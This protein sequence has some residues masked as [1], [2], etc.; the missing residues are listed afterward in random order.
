MTS[1]LLLT[2]G[3]TYISLLNT[4]AGLGLKGWRPQTPDYKGGGVWQDSPLADGRRLAY[5][6]LTNI[7]ETFMLNTAGAIQDDLI[8]T[9]QECRRLL[10]KAANYWGS[11]WQTQPVWLEAR[12]TCETNARYAIVMRGRMGE[13]DNPYTTPFT[14][15]AGGIGMA[16]LTLIV[17]HGLWHSVEPGI[18]IGLPIGASST[19]GGFTL[20]N[21]DGN[22]ASQ[23]TTT[24]VFI[25]NKRTTANLTHIFDTSGGGAFFSGNHLSFPKPDAMLATPP[26]LVGDAIYF[27]I[28]TSV[29][30]SGPFSSLVSNL[31]VGRAHTL[32]WEYWNGAAWFTLVP[33]LN[34]DQSNQFQLTGVKL[35]QWTP[36]ADW[37]TTAVNGVTGWWVRLVINVAVGVSGPVQATRNIYSVTWPQT[38]IASADIGGDV[39]AFINML[40][41]ET[42]VNNFDS[43]R[44]LVGARTLSRGTNFTA[45]LNAVS[46]QNPS[47]VI[48]TTS[49]AQMSSAN[50]ITAPT[51]LVSR[52]TGGASARA[53]AVRL[54][55]TL[56]D[57]LSP[58]Y[59]GAF[60]VFLRVK[61]TAGSAG[62]LGMRGL[63]QI[64]GDT[65]Y[66]GDR[67]ATLQTNIWQLV[68]LGLMR[69]PT[70]LIASRTLYSLSIQI[71]VDSTATGVTADFA[72]LILL[73]VDE[74]NADYQAVDPTDVIA[75][76]VHGRM[77]ATTFPKSGHY[78]TRY[79]D[80]SASYID[81]WQVISAAPAQIQANVDSRLWFLL[82]SR[83]SSSASGENW[84]APFLI[85]VSLRIGVSQRYLSMRG[86]R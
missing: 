43:A 24:G 47:G 2:D 74:W 27:G 17:E 57:V 81:A 5:V 85:T 41:G 64:S 4:V 82:A 70:V 77:G 80:A 39:P 34:I 83:P 14:G 8:F 51:G 58:N 65:R 66:T 53:A 38:G 15:A 46:S 9:H 32:T 40:V 54:T 68:D 50:D 55:W 78:A 11:E 30:N 86:R 71:E 79:S 16:D 13:D 49:T 28:D 44:V 29:S 76:S 12:G 20:G 59:L 22:G 63:F 67:K 25:V 35:I 21:V 61:Q 69:L 36:P 19:Y 62:Q 10:D 3:T 7:I 26:Q 33:S 37:A 60:R 75:S 84:Q 52:F 1:E 72:D 6:R 73:P 23:A 45:Y 56:N 18:D 48:F 31:S 42:T